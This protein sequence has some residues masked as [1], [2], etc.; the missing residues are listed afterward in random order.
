MPEPSAPAASELETLF[1]IANA[2]HSAFRAAMGSP[3]P[4]RNVAMGASGF[5][6]AVVDRVAEAQVLATLEQERRP[7]NVLSE[8]IG[9]I[10]RGGK[11]VLVVD[12]V[13]GSHNALHGIPCVSVSLALG[14]ERLSG[15]RAGVVQDLYT[16]RT[17]WA[18]RGGGA[19]L[20]GVRLRTRPRRSGHELVLMN[21]G[22]HS[23]GRLRE[24]TSRF[25]RVRALG[26]AS[27]EM[28][29]VAEGAADAY[30]SDNV[31]ASLNLRVTDIAAGCLLVGE[32]GGGVEKWG[33]GPLDAPLDIRERVPVL[34]WGDHGFADELNAGGR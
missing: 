33:E 18:T 30:L 10:D 1:R 7:W 29:L 11:D 21:L 27:L 31:P 25:R 19:F 2:V 20:E 26:C 6:T 14:R 15:I 22:A 8:E 5:P 28:A 3:E 34:A 32:A 9:Y 16:G 24:Q 12:P 4:S 13:D 23:A 17:Y